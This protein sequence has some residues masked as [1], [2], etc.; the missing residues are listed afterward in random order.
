MQ[1]RFRLALDMYC[2]ILYN[3]LIYHA[4]IKGMINCSESREKLKEIKTLRD[5]LVLK[6][7][8]AQNEKDTFVLVNLRA[9]IE[10]KLREFEDLFIVSMSEI[11]RKGRQ[12]KSLSRREIKFIYQLGELFDEKL[13]VKEEDNVKER[14]YKFERRLDNNSRKKRFG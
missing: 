8:Q 5:E 11:E 2:P 3:I 9:E 12:G 4:K 10:D 7:T 13:K 1:N 14:R 6:L